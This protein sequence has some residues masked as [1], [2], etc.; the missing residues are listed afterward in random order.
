MHL[1]LQKKRMKRPTKMKNKVCAS[2]SNLQYE[3]WGLLKIGVY[4]VKSILFLAS[5]MMSQRWGACESGS[6]LFLLGFWMCALLP[7]LR[8]AQSIIPGIVCVIRLQLLECKERASLLDGF[9]VVES[10]RSLLGWGALVCSHVSELVQKLV[11]DTRLFEQERHA[12][13]HTRSAQR[14]CV[15]L[16][17]HNQ[18]ARRALIVQ[19][20]LATLSVIYAP[21]LWPWFVF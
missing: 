17:L 13:S 4:L 11:G 15:V 8:D 9:R 21:R 5:Q 14:N 7:L 10:D 20:N 19:D 2:A 1:R 3:E 12:R 6:L 18:A 16:Y